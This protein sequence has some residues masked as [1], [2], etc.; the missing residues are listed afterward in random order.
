[1]SRLEPKPSTIKALLSNAAGLC[2]I[3]KNNLWPLNSEGKNYFAGEV[4]HICAAESNGPRFNSAFSDEDNRSYSNLILLCL[5]HHNEV[6]SD[7]EKYPVEELVRIKKEHESWIR[8]ELASSI[9]NIGYPEL[10]VVIKYIESA[11]A[12]IQTGDYLLTEISEKIR[13]NELSDSTE[14]LV[15]M[16]L[17]RGSTIASYLNS[18]PDPSFEQRLQ[19]IFINKYNEKREEGLRGDDLFFEIVDF[20][21]GPSSDIPRY[22]AAI[23]LVTYFFERCDIFEK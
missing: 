1:M 12:N 20:T 7:I 4:A 17:T 6:D 14:N 5:D 21:K 9:S 15:K 13:K 16:G 2:N 23:G 11:P 22:G 3:C 10:E 19:G 8:S 18:F